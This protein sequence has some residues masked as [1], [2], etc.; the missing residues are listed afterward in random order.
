MWRK[1]LRNEILTT[2]PV[3]NDEM[4]HYINKI[5]ICDVNICYRVSSILQSMWQHGGK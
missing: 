3:G 1:C 4:W 5:N 2:R